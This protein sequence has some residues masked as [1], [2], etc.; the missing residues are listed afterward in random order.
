[1]SF[2][3]DLNEP[4]KGKHL[5]RPNKHFYGTKSM[6]NR[7]NKLQKLNNLIDFHENKVIW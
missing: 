2:W 4:V 7:H 3:A 1:M 5:L 6:A